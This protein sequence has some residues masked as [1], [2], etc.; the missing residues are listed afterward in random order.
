MNSEYVMADQT[1]LKKT[2]PLLER[3]EQEVRG[4]MAFVSHGSLESRKG[5]EVPQHASLKG[6]ARMREDFDEPLA[7]FKDDL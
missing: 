2:H 3:L 7:G 6:T 4:L 1:I 5:S